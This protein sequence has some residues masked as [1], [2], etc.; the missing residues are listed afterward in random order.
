MFQQLQSL[1]TELI[2]SAYQIKTTSQQCINFGNFQLLI[3]GKSHKHNRISLD[4]NSKIDVKK[5]LK[6]TQQEVMIDLAV[7][8]N[9]FLERLKEQAKKNR[10]QM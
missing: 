6:E 5:E 3:N 4:K 10:V 7:K 8:T 2:A 9:S 1:K